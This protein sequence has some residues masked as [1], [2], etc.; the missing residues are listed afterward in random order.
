MKE[1]E[2]IKKYVPKDKLAEALKKYQAGYPVQY[3]IGNVDFFG[4]IIDVDE[5][6][7]IPRFET[8]LLVEKTI[9]LMQKYNFQNSKVLD[10]ATGSG[11]IAIVLKKEI[12]SL[13]VDALDYKDAVLNVAKK[14]AHNNKA[15]IKF[16]K[17]DIL[18]D[19][20]VG[21]Y[22]VIISN[23]PYVALN[24]KVD[25][26]TKYEPQDAI[27]ASDD[28]LE[29]YKAIAKIGKKNLSNRGIIALE[30]GYNQKEHVSNIFKKYFPTA[31]ILAEKD[32]NNFDRY[33]FILNNC[34]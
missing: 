14:N 8:E 3:I 13:K 17:K 6:V 34:E 24:E 20:I 30:I 22:E 18:K 21:K 26:K 29:F 25:E 31:L 32:Y 9:H 10:I 2:L 11:C 7:L 23:P 12:E 28:G 16:L 1:I 15:D 33:I 27:F 4:Y 5:N 19:S